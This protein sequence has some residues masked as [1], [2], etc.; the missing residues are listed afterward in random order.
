VPS[1]QLVDRG[2]VR[3]LWV[4]RA[5]QPAVAFLDVLCY[6]RHAATWPATIRIDSVRVSQDQKKSRHAQ[7]WDANREDRV[8]LTSIEGGP[9]PRLRSA[10]KKGQ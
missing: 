6:D 3:P 2:L 10:V 8:L 7:R 9:G 4:E 1:L 5:T